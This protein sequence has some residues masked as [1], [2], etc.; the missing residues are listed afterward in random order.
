MRIALVRRCHAATGGA[1]LYTA[2]LLAGLVAVGHEVHLF[3]EAWPELPS[4]AQLHTVPVEGNRAERPR[5]FAEAVLRKIGETGPFN[6]VFSLE[7]TLKQDIYRA[8]DGVHRVWLRERAKYAPFWKRP[9]DG[10]G[11]FHRTMKELEAATFDPA[12]TGRVIVNSNMV[13]GEIVECFGFPNERI[14]LV[15]NGVEV[16]RFRE[17]ARLREAARHRFSLPPDAYVLAFVGSGWERKGL[18]FAVDAFRKWGG[19][20]S[21]FLIAGKGKA[22]F[23][24]G[25]MPVGAV[26]EVEQV[27]AAADLFLFP[28]IYE[29]SANVCIEAL[30]SGLPVITTRSNGAAEILEPGVTGHVISRPDAIEEMVAAIRYWNQRARLSPE[31]LPDLSMERNIRETLEL[32][33]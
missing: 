17:A 26:Q 28:P 19:R 25:V 30:A 12:N 4:G 8:G 32:L 11:G 24:E 16:A 3:A 18:R 27:Y 22:R 33:R 5:R 6:V 20:N 29:P 21:R 23:P 14:H 7:R 15:R 9:F 13:R 1:E 10:A 2:R 31:V